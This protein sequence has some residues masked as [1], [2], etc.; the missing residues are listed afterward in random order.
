MIEEFNNSAV[1][2][3]QQTLFPLYDGV[4]SS[5]WRDVRRAEPI[6]GLPR[7]GERAGDMHR[8]IRSNFQ[9]ACECQNIEVLELIEEPEGK[10][11]DYL[12]CTVNPDHPMAVR[13]GH[14]K[15]GEVLRRNR[16]SRQDQAR[17]QG[18]LFSGLDDEVD[19]LPQVTLG[20]VLGDDYTEGGRPCWFLSRLVLL[21]ERY[22]KPESIAEIA[23]YKPPSA[24]RRANK[25]PSVVIRSRE[26]DVQR[27]TALLEGVKKTA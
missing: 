21:R 2:E 23:R 27:F 15:D 25:A 26:T 16:T 7:K 3:I 4:F 11:L 24:E 22:D 10:A 19:G 17:G 8:A 14:Y 9:V 13:W 20:Y 5:A 12:V 6:L 18:Y 1:L